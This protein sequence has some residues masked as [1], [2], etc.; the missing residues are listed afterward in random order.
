M[1]PGVF[2]SSPMSM[3]SKK[4]LEI[5]SRLK[6]NKVLCC[7]QVIHYKLRSDYVNS[8]CPNPNQCMYRISRRD[9]RK[10]EMFHGP[11][12]PTPY[13][14]SILNRGT[15]IIRIISSDTTPAVVYTGEM[16]LCFS[17]HDRLAIGLVTHLGDY[18]HANARVQNVSYVAM[19]RPVAAQL[20][21]SRAVG[22][23]KMKN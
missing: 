3:V 10:G 1:S 18:F 23:T 13:S 11:K 19:F 15:G 16:L 21:K 5:D 17:L 22:G 4:P 20:L 14:E 12:M 2:A 7:H 9:V 6:R 8:F